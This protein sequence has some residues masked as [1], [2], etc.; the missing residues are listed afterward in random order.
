VMHQVERF[1]EGWSD[2]EIIVAEIDLH[3][4]EDET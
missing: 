3:W 2:V 1:V 4:P